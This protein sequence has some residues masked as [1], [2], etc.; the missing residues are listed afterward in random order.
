MIRLGSQRGTLGVIFDQVGTPTYAYDLANVICT[1]IN[2]GIVPGIYHFS[3]EGVC[4]WYDFT[5]AI[6]RL[7]GINTCKVN[8]I[9]TSD[10]PTP[11]K[12]PSYSVLDKTKIKKTFNI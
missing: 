5:I 12:R 9:H 1:A 2:Q 10:Y 8:P 4:S 3:N 11:A 6:H 7:A